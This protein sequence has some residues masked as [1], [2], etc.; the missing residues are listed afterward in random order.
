MV[1]PEVKGRSAFH[2]ATWVAGAEDLRCPGSRGTLA[3]QRGT[4]EYLEKRTDG[5]Y[6]E[7]IELMRKREADLKQRIEQLEKGMLTPPRPVMP[8]V[9]SGRPLPKPPV[10][11]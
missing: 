3:S 7:S 5:D 2:T 1:N 10:R 6:S 8:V 4:R 9:P 11:D